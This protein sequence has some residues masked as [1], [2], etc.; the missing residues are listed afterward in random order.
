MTDD[1]EKEY[2]KLCKK[3]KLPKFSDIDNEFEINDLENTRFFLRNVLRKV[4]EKLEFYGN[5]LNDLLQPDTASLSSMHETRFFHDEEKNSLHILFKKIMK[6]YRYAIELVLE[7]DEK[8]Q[9]EFLNSFFK[10]W[11]AM[12]RELLVCLD[13]MKKSWSSVATIEEDLAYFG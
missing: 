6:S 4:A 9:A 11:L 2:T 7:N 12:K 5:L 3:Y 13:K 10:D 8:K 1:I